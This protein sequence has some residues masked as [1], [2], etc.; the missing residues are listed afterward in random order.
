MLALPGSIHNPTARGCHRLLRDGARLV[1]SVHDVL[2]ELGWQAQAPRPGDAAPAAAGA[3]M[4]RGLL[5]HM[6]SEPIDFDQLLARSGRPAAWLQQQLL[7]LELDGYVARLP[8]G[9]LQRI[10]RG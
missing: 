3:A 10:E 1:E 7:E 8:G 5:E 9:R 6:G 4:P 2:D